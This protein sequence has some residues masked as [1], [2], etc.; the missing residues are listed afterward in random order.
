M[1]ERW[2]Q[3]PPVGTKEKKLFYSFFAQF[4]KRTWLSKENNIILSNASTTY[5]VNLRRDVALLLAHGRGMVVVDLI[6]YINEHN[7]LSWLKHLN[8]QTYL[9]AQLRPC[10]S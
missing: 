5:P 4:Y 10:M 7:I 8:Q 6:Y 1:H 2:L 9:R 3:L